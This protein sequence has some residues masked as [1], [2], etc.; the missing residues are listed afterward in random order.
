M[1]LKRSQHNLVQFERISR[2]LSLDERVVP[3][4]YEIDAAQSA[5]ACPNNM[6]ATSLLD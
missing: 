3:T 6:Y 1:Y 2:V 4:Q 5:E